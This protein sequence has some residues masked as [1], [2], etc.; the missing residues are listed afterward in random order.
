VPE[1]ATAAPLTPIVGH[2]RTELDSGIFVVREGSRITVHFDTPSTR[3]RRR[4]KFERIVRSTL[5]R[6]Y[7]ARADSL[8]ARVPA[9]ALISTGELPTELTER[10]VHLTL[11]DGWRLALLPRTRHTDGGPLVIAYEATLSR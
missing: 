4:D 7:G 11:A 5:P 9:G 8:L 1:P 10:G 3:T 6:I 2:G